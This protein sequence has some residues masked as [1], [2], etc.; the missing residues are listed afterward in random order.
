[1]KFPNAL[2]TVC[3]FC[4]RGEFNSVAS[5]REQ[6]RVTNAESVAATRSA[7]IA[8]RRRTKWRTRRVIEI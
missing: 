8:R 7:A 4:W 1:M 6:T 3:R 5:N 2:E